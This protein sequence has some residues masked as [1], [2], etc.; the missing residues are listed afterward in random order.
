[1]SNSKQLQELKKIYG[2]NV[3]CTNGLFHI[4]CSDHSEV[5]LNSRNCK[6]DTRARYVTIAVMEYVVVTKALVNDKSIWLVLDKNNLR[7]RYRADSMLS[8]IDE[9]IIYEIGTGTIISHLGKKICRLDSIKE[10][11]PLRNNKYLV[12]SIT[13]Y[14]DKIV[15][16]DRDKASLVNMS[17]DKSC[18]IERDLVNTSLLTIML[19]SGVSYKYNLDTRICINTFT[20]KE[21]KGVI[22]W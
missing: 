3:V 2:D 15:Y 21:E 11:I 6:I 7:T 10:V 4:I 12:K 18:I 5:Y 20:G 13:T 14:G 22:L 9:N 8:C 19:M 17:G 16:Y 1:M